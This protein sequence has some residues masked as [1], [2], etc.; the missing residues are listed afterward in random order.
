MV[1]ISCPNKAIKGNISISGSKS[2][3]NRWLI[4][5]AILENN[6]S[7]NNLSNSE[8]TQLLQKA[9]S[10]NTYTEIPKKINIK[11]A[12]TAMRFLTA[13]FSALEN[14]NVILT[15]SLRMKNRP[16]FPLVD[17]LK[18]MGA[19]ISYLEKTGFPPLAIKGKNL[20]NT[21]VS[22]KGDISSQF[23]TALMLIAPKLNKKLVIKFETEL[24]SLPYIEMT[25]K[26]LEAL[27]IEVNW[28]KNGIEIY[29]ISKIKKDKI[30][31]I[32]SD[33]SS[34]S[35]WYSI[36]AISSD[37]SLELSDFKEIS[38]QGD[39]I[40]SNIYKEYFGVKTKFINDKI[41]LSKIKNHK[42]PKYFEIDLIECPDI[43]QT[44]IIS[45]AA[46]KI[47]AK[48]TGLQTLKIKET[49][50]LIAMKNEL[51]KIGV[52]AELTKNSIEIKSFFTGNNQ[53]IKTYNDHRMA[54]SFA[55]FGAIQSI[56]IQDKNVIK[57]SYPNFWKDMIKVGFKVDFIDNNI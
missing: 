36:A 10:V 1:H 15:G 34:A 7:I 16:I 35:Y 6:L 33:W 5:Q 11:H 48:I 38:W 23:I 4:I 45:C 52:E 47:K 46:L 3:S 42:T 17:A 30:I 8:D 19:E 29:P 39:S 50:R 13:Y 40:V 2:E 25:K 41:I 57:K 55:T 22:I 9:L 43:A 51:I 27:S 32:E 54:L 31:N 14:S 12:G 49:D 53:A 56:D 28:I 18:Q 37:Y 20:E 26:Q 21:K 44:I 24:T